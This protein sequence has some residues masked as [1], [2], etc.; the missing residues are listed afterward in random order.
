MPPPKKEAGW[1]VDVNEKVVKGGLSSTVA[2]E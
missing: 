2:A 1:T